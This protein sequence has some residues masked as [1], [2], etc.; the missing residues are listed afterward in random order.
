VEKHGCT[1]EQL[2]E[3]IGR[4]RSAITESL[5]L[6]SMPADVRELCRLA[7]IT[8]KSILLQ[9]VR[10]GSPREMV[11]LIQ[12]LQEAG[13][14]RASARALARRSETGAKRGRPK[15]YVFRYRPQEKLFNLTVQFRKV[16]VSREEILTALRRAIE[17]LTRDEVEPRE[18]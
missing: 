3:R 11:A 6:S 8:S 2:A 16:E 15:A 12:K 5:S 7:D 9:I 10:Q 1:H 13:R 4:S 18:A 14:T 17:E